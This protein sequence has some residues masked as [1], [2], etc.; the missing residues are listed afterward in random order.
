MCIQVIHHLFL[1]RQGI[2]CVV[3]N[4]EMMVSRDDR[5]RERCLQ[6]LKFWIN[7]IV[8][9]SYDNVTKKTAKIIFV[10]TRKDQDCVADPNTHADISRIIRD[11]FGN[12]L[13]WPEVCENRRENLCFF[14]VNN[15]LGRGDPTIKALLEAIEAELDDSDFVKEERPLAYYKFMDQCAGHKKSSWMTLEEATAVAVSSGVD[16]DD[17]PNMLK[18]LHDAGVLMFHGMSILV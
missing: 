17:V 5:M 18:I 8:V 7:S 12:S 11:K 15:K 10:G 2:Y 1:T 3:F 16:E 13:A 6:S 14:P 9:H 4:M